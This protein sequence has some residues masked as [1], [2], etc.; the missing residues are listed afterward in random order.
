MAQ[1]N[2]TTDTNK[3]DNSNSG[4]NSDTS[5]QNTDQNKDQ[6]KDQNTDNATTNDN[7]GGNDSNDS[8]GKGGEPISNTISNGKVSDNQEGT[9]SKVNANK[10]NKTGDAGMDLALE[11]LS[12]QGFGPED[13]AVKLAF[14]GDFSMIKAK[15]ASKG[16]K[17][18]GWE[19]Y[20]AISE[21]H[22]EK[23]KSEK[24][25]RDKDTRDIMNGVF[26][27][28][29]NTHNVL[30]WASE[31]ASEE[32]TSALNKMIESGGLQAQAASMWLDAAYKSAN[33]TKVKG[34]EATKANTQANESL[35]KSY[36]TP[37]EFRVAVA[38]LSSK[39]G[40]GFNERKEYKDLLEKRKKYRG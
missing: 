20:V 11:F 35:G 2:N 21:N 6:N 34:A 37:D 26:G 31:E 14:E 24:E 30:D 5:G 40:S 16:S 29:S 25:S 12:K 23:K 10:F 39:Y 36:V 9:D 3:Q 15:L 17:A 28:E 1:D 19:Q 38:D 4:E 7:K 27:N 18:Q 13:D 8:A 22:F 33:G 32:E